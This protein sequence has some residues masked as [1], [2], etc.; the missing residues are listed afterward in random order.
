MAPFFL[1]VMLH[2]TAACLS[3]TYTVHAKHASKKQQHFNPEGKRS[4]IMLVRTDAG[5]YWQDGMLGVPHGMLVVLDMVT[6]L[7]R[8]HCH[9]YRAVCDK[10]QFASG[11]RSMIQRPSHFYSAC[12]AVLAAIKSSA[13]LPV[14]PSCHSRA[15]PQC[16]LKQRPQNK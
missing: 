4:R 3:Q 12:H 5:A 2:V 9:Q 7:K 11:Q 1:C 10:H 15:L 14:P 16:H 13:Q 8:Q 6:S